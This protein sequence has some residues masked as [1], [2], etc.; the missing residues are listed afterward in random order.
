MRHYNNREWK[1][2]IQG[3]TR[4]LEKKL[5]EEHL[6]HCDECIEKYVKALESLGLVT[7][8]PE[9]VTDQIM[10]AIGTKQKKAGGKDTRQSYIGMFARYIVAASIALTLWHFG[11]FNNLSEGISTVDKLA[12]SGPRVEQMLP[13][14]FGNKMVSE[15][16][17]FFNNIN[18]KGDEWFE[19]KK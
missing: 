19:G 18:V 7:E 9:A 15:I 2:Y 17:S 16:N 11:F 3:T 13:S 12:L 10:I 4:G 5:M 1:E 14:G 6:A 8:A